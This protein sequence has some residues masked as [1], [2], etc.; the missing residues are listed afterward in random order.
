MMIQQDTF[1]FMKWC[2]RF[3]FPIALHF[4]Q[5]RIKILPNTKVTLTNSPNILRSV[6]KWRNFA[7]SSHTV[8]VLLK[9]LAK[10]RTPV[11]NRIKLLLIWLKG[12]KFNIL[13][14]Q[15]GHLFKEKKNC[16]QERR[17]SRRALWP[18]R[19]HRHHQS[20]LQFHRGFYYEL[21]RER[22]E[23]YYFRFKSRK[24]KVQK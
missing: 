2:P 19:L 8:A 21:F 23:V 5:R 20:H 12:W 10:S 1:M 11:P 4:C 3:A 13:K 14:G 7:Q 22:L 16:E 9:V 18:L 17:R 15:Q 24:Q 6:Q